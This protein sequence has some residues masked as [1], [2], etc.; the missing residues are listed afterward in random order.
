M[1]GRAAQDDDGARRARHRALGPGWF[2]IT[3]GAAAAAAL[4]RF[5]LGQ[6][7]TAG[8][9]RP[10]VPIFETFQ[11]EIDGLRTRSDGDAS[12]CDRAARARRRRPVA[13]VRAAALRDPRSCG[14][15]A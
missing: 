3:A 11:V 9:D 10:K 4:A 8:I 6:P 12:R 1:R 2:G 14:R 13:A 5:E 15:L 7:V